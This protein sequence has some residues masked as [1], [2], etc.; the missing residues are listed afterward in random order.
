MTFGTMRPAGGH[1]IRKERY[2]RAKAMRVRD[3]PF[4]GKGGPED[5]RESCENEDQGNCSPQCSGIGNEMI[6]KLEIGIETLR[7]RVR[8]GELSKRLRFNVCA[9]PKS[10][11]VGCGAISFAL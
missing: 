3:T 11:G 7:E 4:S 8:S 2:G 5:R 10:W 1:T 9:Q 6:D